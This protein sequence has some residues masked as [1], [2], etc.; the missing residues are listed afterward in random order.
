MLR[1][2]TRGSVQLAAPLKIG[3]EANVRLALGHDETPG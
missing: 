1:A 3:I 2:A